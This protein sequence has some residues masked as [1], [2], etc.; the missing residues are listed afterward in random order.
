MPLHYLFCTFATEEDHSP[1][2]ETFG[3]LYN[4]LWLVFVKI[5]SSHYTHRCRIRESNSVN[6]LYIH[7]HLHIF[8]CIHNRVGTQVYEPN[9]RTIMMRCES[10]LTCSLVSRLFPSHLCRLTFAEVIINACSWGGELGMRLSF[11]TLIRHINQASIIELPFSPP[12][13]FKT[14]L[15]M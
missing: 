2:I 11:T 7:V 15:H 3:T 14:S 4:I 8:S 13:T 9:G 6:E 12:S 10:H 5:S 1:V